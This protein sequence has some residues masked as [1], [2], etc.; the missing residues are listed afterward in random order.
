MDPRAPSMGWRGGWRSTVRPAR[1]LSGLMGG[2]ADATNYAPGQ[3]EIR[4][5]FSSV[6]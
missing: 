1:T 5:V 4:L 6:P 3:W 2:W